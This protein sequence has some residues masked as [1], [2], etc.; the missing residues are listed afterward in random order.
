MQSSQNQFI[1]QNKNNQSDHESEDDVQIGNCSQ[2]NSNFEY[3]SNLNASDVAIQLMKQNDEEMDDIDAFMK[4]EI[5]VL[6]DE[7]L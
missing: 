4:A 2:D 5:K 6:N 1:A 7:S 3:D